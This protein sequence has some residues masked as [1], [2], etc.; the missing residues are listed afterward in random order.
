MS[1]SNEYSVGI[2]DPISRASAG[3]LPA[4]TYVFG[5]YCTGEIFSL[6]PGG[7]ASLLLD[8]SLNISSFGEDEAGGFQPLV[9]V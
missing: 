6:P 1:G 2:R 8:T 3:A 9:V 7:S 4:G 5:D